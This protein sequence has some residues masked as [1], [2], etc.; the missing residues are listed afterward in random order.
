MLIDIVLCVLQ[1]E[2]ALLRQKLSDFSITGQSF[3][4]ETD[5]ELPTEESIEEYVEH[6][7]ESLEDD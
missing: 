5:E 2:A 1:V 4:G 3:N 7:V 6:L